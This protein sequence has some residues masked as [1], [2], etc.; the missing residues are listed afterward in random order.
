MNIREFA[1]HHGGGV[2]PIRSVIAA[3]QLS[4]LQELVIQA[5]SDVGERSEDVNRFR[6]TLGEDAGQIVLLGDYLRG[7]TLLDP[8]PPELRAALAELRKI[9]PRDLSAMR[10]ELLSHLSGG[11]EGYLP[12]D[13]PRV[14][15]YVNKI[16]GQIGENL[17]K[18]HVGKAAELA[19]SGSQEGWDV[20]VRHADGTYDYVQV[21]LYKSPA[22]VVRHMRKVHEKV[23]AGALEGVDHEQVERVYFAVPEDIHAEV[24]RLA[25]RIDGLSEMLYEKAIPICSQ[26]AASL[27]TEGLGNVGP[28]E[29]AH[30]FD[31]LLGGCVVA[32]SLN[33]AVTG[34]LWYKGCK[35]FSTAVADVAA[36]SAV[37]T[38]GIGIGL[39]A[40]SAFDTALMAGGIG[41]A[42]RIIL[43]RAARSRWDFADFLKDSVR[44]TQLSVAGLRAK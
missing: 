12:F 10:D 7:S 21:K 26:D 27:V 35:D 22:A 41:I 40:E 33:S 43:K 13:D 19:T 16:K 1:E 29:L 37:S 44:S 6:S 32:A 18:Q 17:F 2:R 3:W 15:G 11:E 23:L 38:V 14:L 24:A 28:D 9:D 39:L 31:E 4:E 36:D 20:A 30:F 25:E 34:F 42:A 5:P 8:M